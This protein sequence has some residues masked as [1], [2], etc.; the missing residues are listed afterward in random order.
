MPCSVNVVHEQSKAD[1]LYAYLRENTDCVVYYPLDEFRKAKDDWCQI[2]RKY[3]THWNDMG[4][5]MA[6]Q[7]LIQDI[8][9]LLYTSRCV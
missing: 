4:A 2:Y 1:F 9:C 8:D 7:M 6:A 3:D 5:F